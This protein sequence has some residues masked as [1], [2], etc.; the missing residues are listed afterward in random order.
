MPCITGLSL[1]V[2]RLRARSV[3]VGAA[4]IINARKVECRR[5][6]EYDRD[7]QRSQTRI[8]GYLEYGMIRKGT[9]YSHCKL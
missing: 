9:R 8:E 2:V 6:T 7:Q 1:R 3:K 4:Y 5:R